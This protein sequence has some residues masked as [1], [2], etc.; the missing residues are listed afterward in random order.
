MFCCS[1][2]LTEIVVWF[3]AIGYGLLHHSSGPRD[4]DWL[5]FLVINIHNNVDYLAIRSDVLDIGVS[6]HYA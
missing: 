6:P 4:Q 2:S 1:I 3:C 5:I